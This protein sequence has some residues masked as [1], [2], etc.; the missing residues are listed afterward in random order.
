MCLSTK[1]DRDAIRQLLDSKGVQGKFI[2]INPAGG[3]NPGMVMDS[4]RWPP[5]NFAVLAER[6]ADH[7]G[8]GIILLGGPGDGQLIEAVASRMT[9]RPTMFV[10]G[11]SFGQI[12]ALASLSRLYIGNDTGLTHLAAAAGTRTVM[13]LGPSDP[14]RYAPFAPDTLAL[15]KPT[16]VS[17]SGVA[18][19]IPQ[20]WDWARDGIGV[21]EAEAQIRSFLARSP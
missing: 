4:K 13:I 21:D 1:H 8:A 10:G 9:T 17:T 15:W 16:T 20:N 14:K 7:T 12:A 2:V 11:L 19:G 5:E 18:G 3:R 6:L